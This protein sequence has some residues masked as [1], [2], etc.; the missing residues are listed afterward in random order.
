MDAIDRASL[1]A[2]FA[3]LDGGAPRMLTCGWCGHTDA[4]PDDPERSIYT[5]DQCGTR[6]SYGKT[7]P[8]IA[9]LPDPDRRLIV[10]RYETGTQKRP[11]TTH[12]ALDRQYGAMVALDL[13]SVCDVEAW[14]ALLAWKKA[15]AE[16]PP[17]KLP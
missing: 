11:Q 14:N 12:H 8:R 5:C 7:M 6:T 16:A 9:H 4:V 1:D 15:R 17:E 3:R 13:L 2:A 10:V